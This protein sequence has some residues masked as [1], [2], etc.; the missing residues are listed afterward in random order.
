MGR[1]KVPYKSRNYQFR[2]THCSGGDFE[3]SHGLGASAA[4]PTDG[5]ETFV[6]ASWFGVTWAVHCAAVAWWFSLL[7]CLG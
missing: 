2:D 1:S 6:A 4:V 5:P 3:T 7:G